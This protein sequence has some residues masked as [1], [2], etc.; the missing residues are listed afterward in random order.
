MADVT[1]KGPV[2]SATWNPQTQGHDHPA[3]LSDAVGTDLAA[4]RDKV[5][6]MAQ[7]A[8]NVMRNLTGSRE[9]GKRFEDE[10]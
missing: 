9:R 7:K 5:A 4:L 2:H 1:P 3:S 6:P 10:K 8:V